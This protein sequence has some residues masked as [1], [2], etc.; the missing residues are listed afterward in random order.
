MNAIAGDFLNP[1]VSGVGSTWDIAD[2]LIA[3]LSGTV[4]LIIES[5]GTV[6]VGDTITLGDADNLRLQS[7]TLRARRIEFLGGT[8]T[9]IWDAGRLSVDVIQKTTLHIPDGGV[10][11]PGRE[12]G[13]TFIDGS[14]RSF[15]GATTEIQIGGTT[16]GVNYDLVRVAGSITITNGTLEVSML[17]GF[18]PSPTD[19]FTVMSSLSG[20]FAGSFSNIVSGQRLATSDGVGSFLVSYGPGSPQV[21]LSNFLPALSGDFDLD[22]DVDGNDFLTWQ[23]GGSPNPTSAADLAAWRGNYGFGGST[24]ATAAVPEPR[25]APLVILGTGATA[26][27]ATR[28]RVAA[29]DKYVSSV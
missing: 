23:R 13:E 4:S 28:R 25:S 20:V 14:L 9:F 17:N 8:Q 21:L 6:N 18:V 26:A 15:A 16:P 10:L 5:G 22:G 1:R 19:A 3:G 11:A 29:G 27:L 7:A 24:A 2:D 12:L